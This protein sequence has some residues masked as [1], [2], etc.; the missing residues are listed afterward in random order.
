MEFSRTEKWTDK[1]LMMLDMEREI[2]EP[3]PLVR[4]KPSM[5]TCWVHPALK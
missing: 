3:F 2:A 5:R 1:T 4:N